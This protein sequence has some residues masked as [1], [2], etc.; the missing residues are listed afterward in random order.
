MELKVP[1][2]KSRSGRF[3]ISLFKDNEL[4]SPFR[5]SREE[6]TAARTR[7]FVQFFK[8]TESL[9]PVEWFSFWC[10][11]LELRDLVSAISGL[12]NCIE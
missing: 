8:Y 11:P 6:I 12:E 10:S 7:A 3:Q 1:F 2:K 9:Q 5:E 4:I